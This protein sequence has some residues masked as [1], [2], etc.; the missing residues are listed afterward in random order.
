MNEILQ[1]KGKLEPKSAPQKPGP[2]NIPKGNFVQLK[3]I[4]QL[5]QDLINV[6]KF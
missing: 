6:K 4:K 5:K 2:S 1:L 3:H